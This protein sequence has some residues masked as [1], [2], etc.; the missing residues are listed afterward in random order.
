MLAREDDASGTM[1]LAPFTTL[2]SA[3]QEVRR[4][5]RTG[6]VIRIA[7]AALCC[8]VASCGRCAA[9]TELSSQSPADPR[10]RDEI[11]L[12][13]TRPLGTRCDAAAMSAGLD[14]RRYA[15]ELSGGARTWQRTDLATALPAASELPTI[16]YIHGN[17]VE[18]G[19]AFGHGLKIY[20]SLAPRLPSD[21][22][23]RFVIWSWPA[24]QIR[25][26]VK[27]YT[28]KAARTGAVAWQLAW[29][30]NRLPPDAAIA[31]VGYSYGARVA[32]GTLHLLGGGALEGRTV[33]N[34]QP[35]RRRAHA[36]L[37]A[38]ALD[39]DWLLPTGQ[40][41]RAL[42]QLEHLTLVTNRRDPAMRFY[43]MISD[44]DVRALGYAGPPSWGRLKSQF[45]V[46]IDAFDAT[47]DVG[48]HHALQ[49]YLASSPQLTRAW[50]GL[51]TL[52]PPSPAPAAAVQMV[53]APAAGDASQ[54]G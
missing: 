23:V 26:V 52:L 33:A 5:P 40:H 46:E 13:S 28:V 30:L 31:L 37:L 50:K 10:P 14:C 43:H 47:S 16:V 34:L 3:M 32:T 42:K 54:G 7:L 35:D 53:N 21:T 41:G 6:V 25:G 18:A 8:G 15:A 51:A 29:T 4:P 36:I 11:V 38:A 2:R 12:A 39:A 17:R 48:R 20:R 24:E 45:Q 22:P 44:R 1:P 19:E 27:D 9:A 49:A